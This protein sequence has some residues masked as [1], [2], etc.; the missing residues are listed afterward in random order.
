M[1]MVFLDTVGIIALLDEDDQWHSAASAAYARLRAARVRT[2]TTPHVLLECGNAASRRPYRSDIAE[3]RLKLKGLNRLVEVAS[4]EEEAA[5][6]SYATAR[7]EDAGIVDH[8]SFIV[9]RRLGVTD[10]FTN[11]R[12][13]HAAGFVTLF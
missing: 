3:L 7:E 2:V 11:D 4:E 6:S 9:M 8:I 13:F 1:S 10:A 12:H 5:W